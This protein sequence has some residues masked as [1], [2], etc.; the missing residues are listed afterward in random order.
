MFQKLSSGSISLS[1]TRKTGENE[2][3]FLFV[4]KMITKLF[5]LLFLA[6][7][8]ST[9]PPGLSHC[10]VLRAR[11]PPQQQLPLWHFS[12]V[13]WCSPFLQGLLFLLLNLRSLSV[14]SPRPQHAR[15][16]LPC[17]R[18]WH[19]GTLSGA[20]QAPPCPQVLAFTA[21]SP[22]YIFPSLSPSHLSFLT[23]GKSSAPPHFPD[24]SPTYSLLQP[25]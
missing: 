4:F 13:W 5:T 19:D 7:P 18:S 20:H 23:S 14:C 21:H 9:Q 16:S 2:H 11:R 24:R 12:G 6:S 22:W 8:L 25:P 1:P 3:L 15:P 10:W 17:P